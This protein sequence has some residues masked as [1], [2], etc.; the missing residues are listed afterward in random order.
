FNLY[1]K[2][3]FDDAYY[4][5]RMVEMRNEIAVLEK[6]IRDLQLRYKVLSVEDTKKEYQARINTVSEQ[7]DE[8]RRELAERKAIRGDTMPLPSDTPSTNALPVAPPTEAIEDYKNIVDQIANL[9][10]RVRDLKNN[11]GYKDA[12]PLVMNFQGQIDV[13]LGQRAALTNRFPALA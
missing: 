5:N 8:A 3:Q 6:K 13:L 4:Q 2:S 7:L 12:H 1:R 9:K 11:N 10:G